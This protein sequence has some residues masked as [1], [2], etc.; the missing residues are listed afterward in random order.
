MTSE[1]NKQICRDYFKAFLAR[2]AA[3]M[4]KHV[5]KSF[6]RHDP[7]LD[8][9][10]RGPEGVL[11]LHDALMP[12]F[13]DMKLDLE[14]LVAEGDKVL[15]RLVIRAT[16]AG[17]FGAMAPTGKPI[18]VAVLDLFQIRD[19]VLVEHWAQLDNLGMLKQLGALAA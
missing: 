3:W 10:V 18:R 2:D 1:T 15:V 5:A 17:P 4:E 8:F 9:E 12:A 6:V 7:G 14:D 16:H 19:G 11:Q 13:P